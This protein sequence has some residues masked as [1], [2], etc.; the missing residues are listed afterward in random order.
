MYLGYADTNA[1]LEN[2]KQLLRVIDF[3]GRET[4]IE[5]NKL[6]FYLYNDGSIEKV[7]IAEWLR[8]KF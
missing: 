7:F 2:E 3:M 6:L 5:S 1:P 8:I 4:T